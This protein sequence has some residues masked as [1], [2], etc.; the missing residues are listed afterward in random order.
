MK[1]MIAPGE[2]LKIG[3]LDENG[4]ESDGEFEVHFDTKEHPNSL[5]IKETAGLPGSILGGAEAILYHEYFGDPPHLEDDAY[6]LTTP[7]VQ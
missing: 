4:R 5:L 2:T 3:F 7:S 6:V 1:I